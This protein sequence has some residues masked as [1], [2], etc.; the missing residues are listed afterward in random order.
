MSIK[1][2]CSYFILEMSLASCEEIE[3]TYKV[4]CGTMIKDYT[5]TGKSTI[6]CNGIGIFMAK[7]FKPGE[8]IGVYLGEVSDGFVSSD[9]VTKRNNK[10]IDIDRNKPF[11]G[12]TSCQ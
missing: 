12:N 8:T 7:M 6:D 11:S 1:T 9:Y 3:D 2:G 4:G 10:W 5:Y